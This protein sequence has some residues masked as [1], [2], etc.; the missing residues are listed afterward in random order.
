MPRFL[1]SA[2][3]VGTVAMLGGV[4]AVHAKG[5]SVTVATTAT[6]TGSVVSGTITI[7]NGTSAAANVTAVTTALEVRYASGTCTSLPPGTVSGYCRA[8]TV[9][10][11]PP[12]PIPAQGTVSIPYSIDTCSAQVAK[13]SGA[14]DMRSVAAISTGS[15]SAQGYTPNF[16]PPSQT[17]CP[18]CGNGVIEAGEQC[19]GGGCCLSTCR[20]VADGSPCTDYNVCT[21]TDQ[22][23]SGRCVGSNPVICQA[24]DQCHDAGSCDPAAGTCSNPAKPYGTPCNDDSR[25]TTDD[26]CS[27][28]FCRGTPLNC[29]DGN[30]CTSDSCSDGACVHTNNSKPCEDGMV[31]TEGDTCAGGECVSGPPKDCNDHKTCT[32]DSCTEE[33]ACTHTSTPTC[34]AC[35][36]EECVVCQDACTTSNEECT[37]TC[38]NRFWSC[39]A[40]CTTTYCAP[41]CQ[42]DLGACLNAC[43]D[44]AVC[45]SSCETGNGCGVGCSAP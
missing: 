25:C 43:P 34:D 24:S 35:D 30:V 5:G 29:D 8:A 20:P 33:S 31:C 6:L 10:L 19:D 32:S 11:P 4:D 17:Y 14:K 7:S 18:V 23:Q 41:F 21:Q 3:V 16:I 12:G 13:Y 40:G 22:C 15:Q 27:G 26:I 39:L 28:G 45:Q 2:A 44:V 1:W 36:A 37:T 9:S 38:W 42:V